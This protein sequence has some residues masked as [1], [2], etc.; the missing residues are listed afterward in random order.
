MSDTV[1]KAGVTL[2]PEV[3]RY[4]ADGLVTKFARKDAQTLIAALELLEPVAAGTHVIVP[5]EPTE[6]MIKAG[7]L[8]EWIGH[9]SAKEESI[10][11]WK[12]GQRNA[13]INR[14]RAMIEAA[15]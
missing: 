13:A 4:L 10:T 5:K 6:K 2:L 9:P 12:N 14:Y 11:R 3:R 15:P 1:A 7:S 8:Q